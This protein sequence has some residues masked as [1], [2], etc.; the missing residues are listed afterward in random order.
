M[1]YNKHIKDWLEVFI[2]AIVVGVG[3]TIG[4]TFVVTTLGKLAKLL[5]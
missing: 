4:A 2:G 1:K 3:L 5:S